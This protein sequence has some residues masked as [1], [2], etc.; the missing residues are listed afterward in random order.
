MYKMPAV[1]RELA[2]R[3]VPLLVGGAGLVF[4]SFLF[5]LFSGVAVYCNRNEARNKRLMGGIN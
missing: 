2:E 3:L 4:F 5:T 1:V